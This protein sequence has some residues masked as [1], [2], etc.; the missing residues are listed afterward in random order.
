MVKLPTKELT[1]VLHEAGRGFKFGAGLFFAAATTIRK[2][3]GLVPSTESCKTEP[4]IVG[5]LAGET[6]SFLVPQILYFS[7]ISAIPLAAQLA[8]QTVSA[9]YET[10]RYAIS[11]RRA[12]RSWGGFSGG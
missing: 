6:L 11:H 12:N 8:T 9:V 10:A 7:G 4:Y 3:R 2:A 5:A 1:D